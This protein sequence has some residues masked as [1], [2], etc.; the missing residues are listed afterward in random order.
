VSVVK[1]FFDLKWLYKYKNSKEKYVKLCYVIF[2]LVII[3]LLR[4]FFE[5]ILG[6]DLNGKW[7]SFDSDIL[8]VM[9]VF[10]IY[11]CFFLS[12][13]AHLL[14]KLFKIKVDFKKL[15]ALFFFAQILHLVIPFLD[16][17]GFNLGIPWTF[18]PYLNTGCCDLNPFTHVTN[19]LQLVIVLTPLLFLF[20]SP[21]LITMGI[22][23][24]WLIIGLIFNR[25][26]FKTLKVGLS[27]RLLIT[28]ILFHII[29]WPIYKLFFIFD[30]LFS[31][32]TR[33]TNTHYGYGFYFLVCGIIGIVYFNKNVKVKK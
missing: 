26:M 21:V 10:A 14:L 15:F 1:K 32:I 31:L 20:M 30:Q 4:L 33:I 27:K 2:S 22:T 3:G 13:C 7:Y 12:M 23:F 5:V 18:Q 9:S 29:Y 8:F 24:S 6:I 17:V 25:F 11:L 19:P 16:F 28:L